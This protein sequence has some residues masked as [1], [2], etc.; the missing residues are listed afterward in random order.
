MI[1]YGF[2]LDA[3]VLSGEA[4]PLTEEAA[5][6][7]KGEKINAV[8]YGYRNQVHSVEFVVGDIV[9][10]PEYLD[11]IIRSPGVTQRMWLEKIHKNSPYD[12]HMLSNTKLLLDADGNVTEV[13]LYDLDY[14]VCGSMDRCCYY[15]KR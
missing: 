11:T 7:L 6:M 2:Q 8:S 14:F 5:I 3:A 15:I 13:F 9:S 12:L 4:K 10:K 1:E